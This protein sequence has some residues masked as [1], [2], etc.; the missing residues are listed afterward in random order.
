MGRLFHFG[1]RPTQNP[2]GMRT[3]GMKRIFLATGAL[4]LLLLGA[5]GDDAAS[6]SGSPSASDRERAVRAVLADADEAA[7]S[8]GQAHLGHFLNLKVKDLQRE[9]FEAPSDI[10]IAVDSDH[11]TYCIRAS[12]DDLPSIHPWAKASLSSKDRAPAPEDRCSL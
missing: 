10:S 6:P 1:F 2:L 4:S 12:D 9:G 3:K 11:T 7:K 8:F 5:C